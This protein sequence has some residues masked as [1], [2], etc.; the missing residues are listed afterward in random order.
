[1]PEIPT[2]LPT[3]DEVMGAE[4]LN[5]SAEII[6]F[7]LEQFSE[8][9]LNVHTIHAETEGMSQL[10]TFAAIIRGLKKRGARFIQLNE[11][12]Q[13]LH[14][15]ELPVCEVTRTSLPGRAGW[16]SA[17]GGFHRSPS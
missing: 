14:L 9:G 11:I 17:Q 1:T 10:D 8:N 3:M 2:T 15:A 5:S 6:Q 7:Y 4:G 13:R 16:I 12:A